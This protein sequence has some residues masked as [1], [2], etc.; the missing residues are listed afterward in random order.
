MPRDPLEAADLARR[1]DRLERRMGRWRSLAILALAAGMAGAAAAFSGAASA[2]RPAPA[3]LRVERLAIVDTEGRTRILLTTDGQDGFIGLTD[4]QGQ[5]RAM[6]QSHPG[7]ARITLGDG[8]PRLVLAADPRAVLATMNG[9]DG[10]TRAV[11]GVAG[12]G[13][14]TMVLARPDGSPSVALP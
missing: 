6:I 10:I 13:R 8:R 14:E 2:D 4:A 11:I 12:S 7:G 9:P 1:L 5:T 3:E